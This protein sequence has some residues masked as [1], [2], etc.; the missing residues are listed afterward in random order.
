VR[1][2]VDKAQKEI[3]APAGP[4]N[5]DK[6]LRTCQRSE[7]YNNGSA[8]AIVDELRDLARDVRRLHDPFRSNPERVLIAKD[9]IASRLVR[10]ASAMEGAAY[11]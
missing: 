2:R 5:G 1:D 11:G 7:L 6:M 3:A 10:L 4:R 9:N 8:S